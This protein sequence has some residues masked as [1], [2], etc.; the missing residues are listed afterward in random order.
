MPDF[1]S[2]LIGGGAQLLGGL[3]GGI[4]GAGQVRR[5]QNMLRNNPRPDYEIPPEAVQAASE[6]LPSSQYDLAMKNIQRQQAQA[7]QSA[8]DRRAGIGTLGKTQQITNDATLSLDAANARA[9]QINQ[10]R[11]IGQREKA[12]DWNKKQKY[13]QDYNYGMGL[14]GSGRQNIA[15]GFDRGISGLGMIGSGLVNRK[16]DSEAEYINGY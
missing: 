6:G 10:Q 7:I 8:Q 1:V 16:N 13:I 12:W 14:I 11:L 2:G 5:G 9:R 3:V 15:G 4:V